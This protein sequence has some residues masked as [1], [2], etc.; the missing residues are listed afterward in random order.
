MSRRQF[1]VGSGAVAAGAVLSQF[2][3]VPASAAT[4]NLFSDIGSYPVGGNFSNSANWKTYT[5]SGIRGGLWVH[6]PTSPTICNGTYTKSFHSG[7][8]IHYENLVRCRV[9]G[10]RNF[11]Q[12]MAVVVMGRVLGFDPD[13]GK[14]INGVRRNSDPGLKIHLGHYNHAYNYYVGLI[15]KSQKVYIGVEYNRTY[16]PRYGTI[17]SKS[18]PIPLANIETFKIV[19]VNDQISVYHRNSPD[20]YDRTNDQLIVQTAPG[21]APGVVGRDG[22]PKVT[23]DNKP[24]GM[25]LDG[26]AARM[27]DF[28]A[29]QG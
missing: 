19:W 16:K 18:F 23:Y 28:H 21:A 25:Y 20:P 13:S 27:Y 9:V 4:Y 22:D 8:G 12:P 29:W 14:T 6:N 2:P 17:V 11:R 15:T 5:A 10:K 3:A 7:G 1:L 26:A 24:L